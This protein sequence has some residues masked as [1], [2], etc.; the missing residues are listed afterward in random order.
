MLSCT[1]FVA[2]A[3]HVSTRAPRQEQFVRP[4]HLF[5]PADRFLMAVLDLLNDLQRV[6]LD[7]I[8]F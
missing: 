2:R 8:A 5:A 4:R 3:S 1:R 7:L 6:S